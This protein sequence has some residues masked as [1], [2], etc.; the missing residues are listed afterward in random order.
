MKA[1]V[2]QVKCGTIGICVKECPQ[3]FRFQPGS[4]KATVVVNAVP[5]DLQQKCREV[6][7]MCPNGAIIIEE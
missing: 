1:K 5:A 4:K 7:R 3:V 6:A 2:D